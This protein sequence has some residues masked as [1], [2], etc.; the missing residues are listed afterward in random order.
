MRLSVA[1]RVIAPRIAARRRWNFAKLCA[2]PISAFLAAFDG[3]DGWPFQSVCHPEAPDM[4][5]AITGHVPKAAERVRRP[6]VVT[7]V[8]G[9]FQD[10]ARGKFAF[11]I[12]YSPASLVEAA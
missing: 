4:R 3:Q 5:I 1:G 10:I 2:G 6:R 12:T 8:P 7:L 11:G 9:P